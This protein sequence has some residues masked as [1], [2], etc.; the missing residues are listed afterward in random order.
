MTTIKQAPTFD[1][2]LVDEHGFIVGDSELSAVLQC[3]ADD[4]LEA[5]WD[6]IGAELSE[7]VIVKTGAL[8]YSTD[9]GGKQMPAS[10]QVTDVP[11][12]RDL[13][14]CDGPEIVAFWDAAQALC[15]PRRVDHER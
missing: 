14:C 12:E 8:N 11:F 9:H 4:N 15:H 1:A 6:I 3:L 13:D 5:A 2:H 10:H 7:L